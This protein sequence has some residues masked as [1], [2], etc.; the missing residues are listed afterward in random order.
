MGNMGSGGI[1]VVAS[2]RLPVAA[3]LLGRR[4]HGTRVHTSTHAHRRV[5]DIRVDRIATGARCAHHQHRTRTRTVFEC[6][7]SDVGI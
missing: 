3:E 6:V 2:C 7:F 4:A 1:H 5:H